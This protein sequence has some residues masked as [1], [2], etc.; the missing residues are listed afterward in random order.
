[1]LPSPSLVYTMLPQPLSQNMEHASQPTPAPLLIHVM[2]WPTPTL[3]PSMSLQATQSALQSLLPFS[4]MMQSVLQTWGP[5]FH[6]MHNISQP[7]PPSSLMYATPQVLMSPPTV[8]QQVSSFD[9]SP[10][11]QQ[12]LLQS[13][14]PSPHTI[15]LC[16]V[17]PYLQSLV[18][19]Y[20]TPPTLRPLSQPVPLHPL[21]GQLLQTPL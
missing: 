15:V 3:T 8:A 20:I 14:L 18:L 9:V 13:V 4:P 12:L 11:L 16:P 2:P 1:M 19:Q 5:P 21:Q 17:L 6:T 7:L 10:Q